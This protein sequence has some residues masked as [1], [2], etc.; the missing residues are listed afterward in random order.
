MFVKD[1]RVNVRERFSYEQDPGRL[2]EVG[3]VANFGGIY[4]TVGASAT[5]DRQNLVLN[6][7]GLFGKPAD[8]NAFYYGLL[9]KESNLAAR[10]YTQNR[11]TLGLSYRF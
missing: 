6:A 5:W 10:D 9:L 7:S 2:G 8:V 3:G 4:N 1:V 11:V